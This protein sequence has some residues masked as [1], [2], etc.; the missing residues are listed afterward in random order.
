M[1]SELVGATKLGQRNLL[2][3]ILVQ[4]QPALEV[5]TGLFDVVFLLCW[6]RRSRVLRVG[7]PRGSEEQPKNESAPPRPRYN[8]GHIVAQVHLVALGDDM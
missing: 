7:K 3:A 1:R 5:P 8:H 4:L 6:R 2:V